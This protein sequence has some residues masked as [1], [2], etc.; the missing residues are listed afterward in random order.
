MQAPSNATVGKGG[1]R[2]LVGSTP[3]HK[4]SLPTNSDIIEGPSVVSKIALA[5]RSAIQVASL[6][7]NEQQMDTNIINYISK[8]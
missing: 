7:R 8:Q 1:G 4:Y 3:Q 2:P 6:I 5:R